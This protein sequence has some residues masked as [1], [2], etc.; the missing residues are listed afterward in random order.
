MHIQK[1]TFPSFSADAVAVESPAIA[2]ASPPP[3]EELITLE[4]IEPES[5]VIMHTPEELELR[6]KLGY[7]EGYKQAMSERK[8]EEE[9]LSQR[10]DETLANIGI[11]IGIGLTQFLENNQERARDLATTAVAIARKIAGI[12]LKD[13][14]LAEV[15]AIAEKCVSVLYLEPR[16]DMTVHPSLTD[17]LHARLT[18]VLHDKGFKGE[19]TVRGNETMA[20]TDCRI[21]WQD[22]MAE[23]NKQGMIDEIA[24]LIEGMKK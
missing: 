24:A 2:P 19:F 15:T 5:E 6:Y 1:Y 7:D 4:I 18:V 22:G 14:P 9:A 21:E 12:A 8:L 16:I 13:D 3:A 20:E 11:S 10:M 23:S 17:E